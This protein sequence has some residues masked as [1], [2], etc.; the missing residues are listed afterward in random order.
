MRGQVKLNTAPGRLATLARRFAR[1]LAKIKR[2]PRT[3]YVVHRHE[4]NEGSTV[5][6]ALMTREAA[7]KYAEEKKEEARRASGIYFDEI[8]VEEIYLEG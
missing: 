6:H 8:D 2:P 5:L 3:I 7:E 1:G 4:P